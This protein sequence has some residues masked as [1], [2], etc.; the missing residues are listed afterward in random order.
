[1]GRGQRGAATQPQQNTGRSAGR[2]TPQMQMQQVG[3]SGSKAME[4][5][6]QEE[7]RR[8]QRRAI[9]F[10]PSHFWLPPGK[11]REIIILDNWFIHDTPGEGGVLIKEHKIRMQDGNAPL[12]ELCH[13]VIPGR[14]CPWCAQGNTAQMRFILTV[15]EIGEWTSEKTGI[16]HQGSRRVLAIPMGMRATFLGLQQTAEAQGHTMRGMVL[17][18]LRGMGETDYAIGEPQLY[19]DTGR[20]Y[21]IIDEDTMINDYGNDELRSTQDPSRVVKQ[22]DEDIMPLDY[23]R[24]FALPVEVRQPVNQ[25]RRSALPPALPGSTR[26]AREVLQQNG[27]A[28]DDDQIDFGNQQQAAPPQ[29]TRTGRTRSSATQPVAA[30]QRPAAAPR[31][32]KR[33]TTPPPAAPRPDSR[34]NARQV[35]Q[36]PQAPEPGGSRPL[37]RQRAA[38]TQPPPFEGD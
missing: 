28:Q 11:N 16:T 9:G 17:N 24:V 29:S 21:D 35:Q 23:A 2:S 6:E 15:Y 7:A 38:S 5:T 8:E 18:M 31:Q 25:S 34:Q 13:A 14:H 36:A 37:R 10:I 12:Y 1:M 32:A 4:V 19:P 20:L 3:L 27:A 26:E 33:A 30:P 22:Q